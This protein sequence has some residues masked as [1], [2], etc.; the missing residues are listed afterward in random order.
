[1]EKDFNRQ[2]KLFFIQNRTALVIFVLMILNGTLFFL[3]GQRFGIK[4]VRG[5]SVSAPLSVVKNQV[6]INDKRNRDLIV[7]TSAFPPHF[8]FLAHSINLS[9]FVSAGFR[10]QGLFEA[11]QS[12]FIEDLFKTVAPPE[13]SFV[14]VGSNI[15]W[16][17]MLI[18]NTGHHVY[19]IEGFTYNL[20]L[21]YANL[22]INPH[23]S[24][25]IHVVPKAVTGPD[26]TKKQLCIK[27]FVSNNDNED[28]GQP[29]P[30]DDVCQKGEL[31]AA[32]TVDKELVEL[33]S[34]KRRP[35]LV[36]YDIEGYEFEA[37]KGSET[38]LTRFKPCYVLVD[39]DHIKIF[40]TDFDTIRAWMKARDY[41]LCVHAVDRD[42]LF[43]HKSCSHYAPKIPECE[44]FD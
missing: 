3:L 22:A 26:Y 24:S 41:D 42:K 43:Q 4:K 37:M 39:I 10:D 5:P 17:P 21:L 35:F 19:A 30:N 14:D 33:V 32:S 12:G 8:S 25:F 31:A 28:N 15:G 29:Q 16:F 9:R 40:G 36:N 18:A 2:M 7:A 1:M 44:L 27:P 13:A 23:L 20:E 6:E 38:F 11:A 34:D